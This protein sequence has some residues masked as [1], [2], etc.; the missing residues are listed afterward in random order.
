[1]PSKVLSTEG[2]GLLA[3]DPRD[4]GGARTLERT[5]QF[6]V[7]LLGAPGESPVFFGERIHARF[8]HP[9]EPLAHQWYRGIRRLFLS[10]FHV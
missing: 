1:M 7:A 10:Q 3:T 8:E 4:T 6:D 9:P 2:G 5:F